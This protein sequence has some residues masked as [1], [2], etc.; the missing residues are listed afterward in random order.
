VNR[1]APGISGSAAIG[2]E[3][4]ANPGIWSGTVPLT[5]NYQWLR[6][7]PQ[8][9][10]CVGISGATQSQYTPSQADVGSSLRVQ[11]TATNGAGS[12]SAQ[13]TAT[14]IVVAN[15]G[16]A[17]A[18]AVATATQTAAPVITTAQ[19]TVGPAVTTATQT[20]SPVIATAQQTAAPVV[21]TAQQTV[22]PPVQ[23]VATT[24]QPVVQPVQETVS[25]A[26]TTAVQSL[27]PALA[28]QD[29]AVAGARAAAG[30][31]H[32]CGSH[33]CFGVDGNTRYAQ[34]QNPQIYIGEVGVYRADLSTFHGP[35][36]GS[37]NGGPD[38]N[39]FNNNAALAAI[40]TWPSGGVQSYYE[41]GG[42]S[43]SL[44]GQYPGPYCF[45]VAQ[46]QAALHDL[47][48]YPR[49]RSSQYVLAADVEPGDHWDHGAQADNRQ[50]LNGFFDYVSDK[51]LAQA[52]CAGVPRYPSYKQQY[53]VYSSNY[54]EGAGNA[55]SWDWHFWLGSYGIM[56]RALIWTYRY[57]GNAGWP[58]GSAEKFRGVQT[59]TGR[60]G[61][62]YNVANW[63]AD[64]GYDWA[65]Q[66]SQPSSL[67]TYD[68]VYEPFSLPVFGGQQVGK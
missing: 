45:G 17:V 46:G 43:S 19:Q 58:A 62:M 37:T 52:N 36:W 61:N 49:Y 24:V 51:P 14:G 54:P 12:A 57:Q 68:M 4:T 33:Y 7:D 29:R 41:L 65:W 8:G 56:P 13:S 59:G 39:C 63:F 3:L 9:N 25:P 23:Q 21:T 5:F 2:S 15:A 11:V 47:S 22:A 20:A 42:A 34:G 28:A 48:Q 53:A 38:G 60:A 35:C 1:S 50:V 44:E 18:S 30:S 40:G 6:C 31:A 27:D 32:T 55:Y 66:F 16:P 67:Q 26:I 64:S 10:N